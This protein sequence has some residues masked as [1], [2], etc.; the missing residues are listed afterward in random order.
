[1]IAEISGETPEP[2]E[3]IV[4]LWYSKGVTSLWISMLMMLAAAGGTNHFQLT[5]AHFR[6]TKAAKEEL[7]F[8]VVDSELLSAAVLHETNRRRAEKGLRPLKYHAKA[9]R[10]AEIQSKI[11]KKRGSISHENPGNALYETLP[12]RV[13]AAGVNPGFA[14]ENVATAFGLRYE[15][16]KGFF[17]REEGG[18][19]VFSYSP[20]GSSIRPHTYVSFAE[21]LV[22]AW[23]NSPGHRD[24]ILHK[25]PES[26]GVSCVGSVGE[27]GLPIFYCTQVF[28][29]PMRR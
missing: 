15:S 5:P 1:V 3:V 7:R 21:A 17:K 6:E 19:T 23:M 11:M 24:N 20:K 26:L 2:R 12:K 25:E 22:E 28:L 27:S 8:E 9:E 14:A 13:R 18:K 10:A 29:A 4:S 16:G